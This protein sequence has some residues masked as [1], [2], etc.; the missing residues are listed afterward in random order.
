MEPIPELRK[1]RTGIPGLDKMLKGG[2]IEGRPYLISGGPGAGKS[3]FVMQFLMQSIRKGEEALY[4]TL[5]EPYDEIR[6][7]MAQ[8]GWDTRQVRI[9]DVSPEAGTK[10]GS[11]MFSLSYLEE[12]LVQELRRHPHKRVGLD[13]TSTLRML[14]DHPTG[15][16]RRILSIM[17][18]LTEARCTSLIICETNDNSPSMEGFLARGVIK[19]YTTTTAG[20][21]IRAIGIE[22]MRGTS[23]DEH[24]R[25]FTIT[26]QGIVIAAD[27]IA[28]ETFK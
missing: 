5:E 4:I 1:I 6:Q 18:I 7:N 15:G 2:L 26:D 28:F 25:P 22:K 10:E 19:L 9:L 11:D 23:F 12:E 17:K 13:S 8:F 16:R 14:E 21:K 3:I 24:I 27:E 20:E